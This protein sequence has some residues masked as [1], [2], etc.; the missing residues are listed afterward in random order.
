[1]KLEQIQTS[2]W[3]AIFPSVPDF[4]A[5]DVFMDPN[6][7][8]FRSL[9]LGIGDIVLNVSKEDSKVSNV[10]ISHRIESIKSQKSERMESFAKRARVYF[11]SAKNLPLK[12]HEK[13][14][15]EN[16]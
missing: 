4:E 10:S 14:P 13:T 3:M 12:T 2:L 6:G 7:A 9:L 15:I 16:T 8:L 5:N 11:F 1:M